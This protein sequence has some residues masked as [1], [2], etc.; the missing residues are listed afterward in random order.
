MANP[1]REKA[2]A[3]SKGKYQGIET[4]SAYDRAIRI[5]G[6]VDRATMPPIPEQGVPQFEIDRSATAPEYGSVRIPE[7]QD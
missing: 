6:A 3:S 4:Q 2:S 7:D 5:A 1:Y